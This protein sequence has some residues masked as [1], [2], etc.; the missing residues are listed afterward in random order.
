MSPAAEV[1]RIAAA[2]P[3]EAAQTPRAE[4]ERYF[5]DLQRQAWERR[6]ASGSALSG[7]L[8]DAASV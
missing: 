3:P 4:R 2:Y 1:E 5:T 6:F 8:R 7:G